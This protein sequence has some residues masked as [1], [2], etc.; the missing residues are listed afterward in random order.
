MRTL[1]MNQFKNNNNKKH[2]QTLHN[3]EA[4]R[5]RIE[6]AITIALLISDVKNEEEFVVCSNL[7]LSNTRQQN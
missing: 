3:M 5:G 1:S 4:L 7:F 6:I 2:G